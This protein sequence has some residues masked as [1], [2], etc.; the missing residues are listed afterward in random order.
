MNGLVM[1][2][3]QSFIFNIAKE[4][5]HNVNKKRLDRMVMRVIFNIS[6]FVV[7]WLAMPLNEKQ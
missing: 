5:R 1:V 4:L 3:H 6:S 7:F 2:A